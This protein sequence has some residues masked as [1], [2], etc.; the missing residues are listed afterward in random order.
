MS[1]NRK[2]NTD[3]LWR[4]GSNVKRLRQG[5]GYTQS[6][7]AKRCGLTKSY[8][9]KIEQEL[10]NISVANLEALAKG[11]DC[12]LTDLTMKPPLQPESIAV[13]GSSKLATE[14]TLRQNP[15]C[16]FYKQQ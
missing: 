1:K 11:L 5:R 3:I 10:L 15:P 2:P 16:R 13:S 7:L 9:S 8:I 6:E 14:S 4:L 12:S